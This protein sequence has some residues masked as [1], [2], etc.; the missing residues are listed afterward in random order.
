MWCPKA[1]VSAASASLASPAS[2]LLERQEP[3]LALVRLPLSLLAVKRSR[4]DPQNYCSS[5]LA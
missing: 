3:R 5:L 4:D 1:D 2:F